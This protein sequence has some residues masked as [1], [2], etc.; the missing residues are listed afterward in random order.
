MSA[1]HYL[2]LCP[3]PCVVISQ[4]VVHGIESLLLPG[5]TSVAATAAANATKPAGRHL[6]LSFNDMAALDSSAFASRGLLGWGWGMEGGPTA[7]MDAA[8]GAIEAA[9][10][11]DESVYQATQQVRCVV[12]PACS[13][14]AVLALR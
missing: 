11:G 4:M 8:Q 6:L 10:N 5:N 1:H 14:L 13:L 12:M 7:E 3:P 9:A 2:L